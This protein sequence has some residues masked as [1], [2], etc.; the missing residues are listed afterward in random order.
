M[1]GL[2]LLSPLAVVR[3]S[4][5]TCLAALC[6]H[7]TVASMVYVIE[8]LLPK[9]ENVSETNVRLGISEAL[10]RKKRII[11]RDCECDE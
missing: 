3:Y 6:M 5:A 10:Y 9:L 8:E 4:S 2:G 11:V 1:V 7:I